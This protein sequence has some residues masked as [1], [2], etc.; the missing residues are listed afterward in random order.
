[1]IE[2]QTKE[3]FQKIQNEEKVVM[4][5]SAPWCG[6]CLAIEPQLPEIETLF[7]DFKF[8][9]IDRDMF[10]DECIEHDILG[11]PSFLA[12][13]KGKEVARFVS[14]QYKSKEEIVAF[15]NEARG[16]IL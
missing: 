1:M 4:M 15:L 2:V 10:I 5:F 16:V 8:Y 6:D 12:F 9:H 3:E 14:K 7:S 11:I 13:H